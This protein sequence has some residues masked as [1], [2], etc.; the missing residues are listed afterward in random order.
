MSPAMPEP[1][2]EGLDAKWTGVVE[3]ARKVLKIDPLAFCAARAEAF[4]IVERLG[5][6]EKKTAPPVPT[7]GPARAAGRR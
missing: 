5:L 3:E 1:P 7:A 2:L 6:A 4:Q